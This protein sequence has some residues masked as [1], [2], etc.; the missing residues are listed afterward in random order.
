MMSLIQTAVVGLGWFMG[1]LSSLL[2]SSS[3][4]TRF[5]PQRSS[6]QA[7]VTGA[8]PS[9]PRYVPSFLSRMGFSIATAR[10]FS[11]NVA[12]SHALALSANQFLRK[13]KS[14][15]VCALGEN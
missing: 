13:K 4:R 1:W 12:N 10:R 15:R 5:Y 6:G 9:P 3:T 11:S 8:I 2:L 14:F 7:V